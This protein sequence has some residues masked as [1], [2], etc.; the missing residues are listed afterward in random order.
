MWTNLTYLIRA[1][2]AIYESLP[3]G[4]AK[5]HLCSNG[6]VQAS[7]TDVMTESNNFVLV[8]LLIFSKHGC[9]DSSYK[10]FIK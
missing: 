6:G 9:L 10:P 7:I 3:Q 5:E 1:S 4:A 2:V 8:D